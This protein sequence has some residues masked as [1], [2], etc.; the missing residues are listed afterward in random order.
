MGDWRVT[1][2][3]RADNRKELRRRESFCQYKLNS[4]FPHVLNERKVPAEYN[5]FFHLFMT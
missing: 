1:L 4:F 5:F 2:I 3:D